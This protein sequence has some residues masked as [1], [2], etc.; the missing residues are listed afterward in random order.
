MAQTMGHDLTHR[1]TAP[2]EPLSVSVSFYVTDDGCDLQTAINQLPKCIFKPKSFSRSWTADPIADKNATAQK[3]FA[4]LPSQ[5]VIGLEDLG[6]NLQD[7]RFHR[8]SPLL[9]ILYLDPLDSHFLN[10]VQQS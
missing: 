5:S 10:F 7:A 3:L 8:L 2:L 6:T 4:H 9:M 1:G